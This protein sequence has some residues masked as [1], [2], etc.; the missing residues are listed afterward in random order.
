ML[1]KTTVAFFFLYSTTIMRSSKR[2]LFAFVLPFFIHHQV[3]A[4]EKDAKF[5]LEE[6]NQ[7][8]S[9]GKFNDAI[10]SYDTAIRKTT[11]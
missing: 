3:A 1:Q 2:L 6:G 9:S 11:L 8:L 5:Y 10:L 7:Y 4:F